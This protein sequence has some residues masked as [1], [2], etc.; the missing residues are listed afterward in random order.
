MTSVTIIVIVNSSSSLRFPCPSV[1][2]V[3]FWLPLC[4]VTHI[5]YIQWCAP[6]YCHSQSC[7]FTLMY[8]GFHC[9]HLQLHRLCLYY[10]SLY[11]GVL[12]CIVHWVLQPVCSCVLFTRF[13]SQLQL[14]LLCQSETS[15]PATRSLVTFSCASS[16]SSFPHIPLFLIF[17]LSSDYS[18]QK[19]FSHSPILYWEGWRYQITYISPR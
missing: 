10:H 15:F 7:L 5:Y 6:M 11:N 2:E 17:L 1:Q 8:T 19:L 3:Q 9:S 18:L 4:I 12:L 13:R 14:R 16:Y